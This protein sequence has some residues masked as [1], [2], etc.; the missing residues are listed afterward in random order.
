MTE[1]ISAEMYEQIFGMKKFRMRKSGVRFCKFR[2][3]AMCE[4]TDIAFLGDI[5]KCKVIRRDQFSWSLK[6][7]GSSVLE[8][9]LTEQCC[10]QINKPQIRIYKHTDS[11]MKIVAE[12]VIVAEL[13]LGPDG[14]DLL[15]RYSDQFF[16]KIEPQRRNYLLAFFFFSTTQFP[17]RYAK[18]GQSF[19]A[20]E[21]LTAAVF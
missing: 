2:V 18:A 19:V 5:P 16:S 21:L 12:N 10:I 14:L 17:R 20:P 15:L 9:Q 1:R 7:N 8:A 3:P 4:M 13:M 6:A 11:K